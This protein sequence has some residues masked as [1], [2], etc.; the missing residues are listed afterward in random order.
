MGDRSVGMTLACGI[1]GALF[2]RERTG[3]GTVVD[4][5]LLAAAMHVLSSDILAQLA[6]DHPEPAPTRAP[7]PNPLAGL[8]RT[9]DGR[10]IQ[11]AFLE[12]D[13]YWPDFC[14]LIDRPD[15]IANPR[16]DSLTQCARYQ[17]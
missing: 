9:Q 6:G 16:F 14:Q 2:N 11:I 5:S 4:V 10:H 17:C 12:S 1:A 7:M 13:R 15:L 3:K 8:Y